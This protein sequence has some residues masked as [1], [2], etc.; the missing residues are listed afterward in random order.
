[1]V[2]TWFYKSNFQNSG[3]FFLVHHAFNPPHN[4]ISINQ[5]FMYFFIAIKLDCP[6]NYEDML[7][8]SGALSDPWIETKEVTDQERLLEHMPCRSTSTPPAP[9]ETWHVYEPFFHL[10]D[11]TK[12]KMSLLQYVFSQDE[13]SQ[14][15]FNLWPLNRQPYSLFKRVNFMIFQGL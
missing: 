2:P 3:Q 5:H 8:L 6:S 13:S 7:I 4:I 12:D 9:Y 1:M 14:Y 15:V 10:P 11:H